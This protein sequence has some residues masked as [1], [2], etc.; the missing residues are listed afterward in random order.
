MSNKKTFLSLFLL[1]AYFYSIYSFSHRT[2]IDLPSTIHED[3]IQTSFLEGQVHLL[4][5]E[6][7]SNG[8]ERSKVVFFNLPVVSTV[9]PKVY[10]I[11]KLCF[12]SKGFSP[13]SIYQLSSVNAAVVLRKLLI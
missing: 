3:V 8:Y 4:K 7:N 11:P 13:Y 1:L 2:N 6:S 5:S 9:I 12:I 10:L